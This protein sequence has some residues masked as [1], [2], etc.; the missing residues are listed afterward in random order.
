MTTRFDRNVK[1]IPEAIQ[2]MLGFAADIR[3]PGSKPPDDAYLWFRA[4]LNF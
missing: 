2:T 1:T 3:P 4:L